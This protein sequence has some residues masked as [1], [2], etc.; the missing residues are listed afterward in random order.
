MGSL[1]AY[2][3]DVL[4]VFQLI[5]NKEN[6]ITKSIVWALHKC[7]TFLVKI[8]YLIFGLEINPESV[9][10]LYQ[11]YDATNGITDIEITDSN[12]FYCIIEAKRG[13]LLPNADQLAKYSLRESLTNALVKH[14]A[15]VSMS[16]CS[17]E[18]ADDNLPFQEKNGIPIKHISWKRIYKLAEESKVQSNNAQKRLLGELVIYL[19]GIMTSQNKDSNWV[20]VVSLAS[21]KPEGSNISWI[22]IVNK[23]G[24][25]FHPVGVNGWPKEPPNYIAFRYAGKLQSIHHIE[26]YIVSKNMHDEIIEMP[27]EVWDDNHFIYKLGPAIKPLKEVKTGNI[28]R[29]GR[30][31]AMLDTLLTAD[32]ISEAR[33]ISKER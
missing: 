23:C 17:K 29:S 33:D 7:P 22:E 18:Y 28:Y 14:K 16:E 30:V 25:Y 32:T 12:T 10:I 20:Y 5:G 6:D 3:N 24:R 21:G 26:D 1:K 31:W 8:I 27:D 13:W 9:D 19:G 2:D 15:I 4:S 11:S